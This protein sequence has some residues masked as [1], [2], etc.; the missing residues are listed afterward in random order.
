MCQGNGCGGIISWLTYS[1]MVNSSK[2]VKHN[3]EIIGLQIELYNK[4]YKYLT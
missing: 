2:G 4:E 3:E 1:Q